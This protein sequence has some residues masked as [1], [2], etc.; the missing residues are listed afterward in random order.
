MTSEHAHSTPHI[1]AG[2]DVTA[3]KLVYLGAPHTESSC[4][5]W[6]DA[7][8]SVPHTSGLHCGSSSFIFQGPALM[9]FTST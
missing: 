4:Y 2:A 1:I 7:I 3:S 9:S 8:W 5:T 6:H